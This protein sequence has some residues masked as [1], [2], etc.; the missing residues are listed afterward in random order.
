MRWVVRVL[1]LVGALFLAVSVTPVVPWW[2]VHLAGRWEEARGETLIVL[3]G[4]SV[5]GGMLGYSSYNRSYH[6]VQVWREGGVGEVL[7]LGRKASPPMREY[8]IQHGV[9]AEKVVAED[10]SETTRENALAAK[11]LLAGKAGK[12]VLLTSDFHMARA[13]A[14]FR[15]VGLDVVTAPCPDVGKRAGRWTERW[16]LAWELGMETGKGWGYWWRGWS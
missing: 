9:P 2:A 4:D 1:A 3:G 8:L 13:A 6:A 7:I 10:G 16:G 5:D 15:K 11:R 12:K 14:V